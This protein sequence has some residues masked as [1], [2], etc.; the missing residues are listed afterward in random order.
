LGSSRD[1]R[2]QWSLSVGAP[3]GKVVF[4][5]VPTLPASQNRRSAADQRS[6][7]LLMQL[8][9]YWICMLCPT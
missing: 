1:V 2:R 9:F 7:V 5:A 8:E 3:A 6:S 4:L